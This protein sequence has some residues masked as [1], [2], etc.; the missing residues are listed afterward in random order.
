VL[1]RPSPNKPRV[2]FASNPAEAQAQRGPS[3]A[4]A[5]AP[6]P[7]QPVAR[8]HV[9]QHM[10]S[11]ELERML[12]NTWEKLEFQPEAGGDVVSARLPS[13]QR[14]II[15]IDHRQRTVTL[16]GPESVVGQWRKVVAVL[17]VKPATPDETSE[18][19]P[20]GK[21]DPAQIQYAIKLL[22]TAQQG[23]AAKQ[24]IQFVGQEQPE[25]APR[26]P[27]GEP[28]A[29]MV[30]EADAEGPIGPVT[31]EILEDRII[32]R[33]KARDVA[34]VRKIIQ[35]IIRDFEVIRP[36][37]EVHV[38]K[39]LNDR[40]VADLI[41]QIYDTVF[42]PRTARV[43]ITPLVKPNALLLIGPRTAIE[44]VK[45]LI[46]KLDQP[47]SPQTQ[48]KVF[49]LQHISAVDAETTVRTF[50]TDRPPLVSQEAVRTGLGTRVNVV[51]E[52][53][54]NSLI[55]QASPR[56]LVEVGDL[57]KRLDV[58][59]S[60]AT[61]EVRVFRLRNSLA[62]ELAPVLQDAI[63][64][65]GAPRAT[66]GQQQPG[67]QPTGQP[68]ATGTRSETTPRSAS[69]QF[70]QIDERGR[71]IIESGILS[72]VRVNA[73][74]RA[75][76]LI[77][78]GP[79]ASMEL[80]AALIDQLD[81]LPDAAASIKVF[82]LTNGDA[83][84]IITTLQ[85]LFGQ[86]T[87]Q[88]GGGGAQGLLQT[89]TT[90]GENTLVPLRFSFDQRTNSIIVSGAAGDIAVVERIL[91]RLDESDVRRRKTTVY[92]LRN[93]PALDVS[94]AIN[95][96][97]QTQRQLAQVAPGLTSQIE[98]I[99]R[100]VVVVPEQVSN[101]LLVSATP[102][103]YEEIKKIVED[104]DR[105]PPMVIIQ[106]LIAEVNLDNVDEFG[107]EFGLQDSLLFDRGIPGVG[108]PFNN[109]PLGNSN[110][111]TRENLAGQGLSHFSVGRTNSDL[112]YGGLVL[113]ASNESVSIL[114]RALQQARRLQ[115]I[116][117]P[118]VQTLDNQ[119]A[120][121][122]VGARVPFITQSTQTT[123]GI[124]NT[125]TLENIGILLGVTPRTSPD[126]LIVMEI[127][128]EK[129][130]LSPENQGIPIFV[131]NEGQI[132]RS[133]QIFITTAQTTVSATSGQT[134][135]LGGLI[136]KT[137]EQ[138]T[139]RV[140]YMSDIP[141]LG[142]LF[143]Y[144]RELNRKRELLIIMTPYVART[145]ED[146][147]MINAKETERMNWCLADVAEAHGELPWAKGVG[148]W[149]KLRTPLIFP[150]QDPTGESAAPPAGAEENRFEPTER[151]PT[152]GGVFEQQPR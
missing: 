5:A 20:L 124:Q 35:D 108:F 24:G 57:L 113:S 88:G 32:V 29:P 19:L 130:E 142:R 36:E 95:Q 100:E 7:A 84:T 99:E 148:P 48:L 89:V 132:I 1:D 40:A 82:T 114:I 131:S 27:P 16:E 93:A 51:A 104:L 129:S 139:R 120:F 115:V 128:A 38:L 144:D 69:L 37:I 31:I 41:G 116:S 107:A 46:T 25:P 77:V 118:Q 147:E 109:L 26:Q 81:Q 137:R 122:Q 2:I 34:R 101:S 121:V 145:D 133:P 4:P 11:R 74:P 14:A 50:F 78:R 65:Q 18:I 79:S 125:T 97:L 55:V 83:Q 43:S 54:S 143:R 119:P 52:F 126:G 140:P 111:A 135:I 96:F 10:S 112:G 134:V 98:Q 68:S 12:V 28:D 72:D 87:G 59:D 21:A 33:G 136:T 103:Y 39:H 22:R 61:S 47:V 15:R 70:L 13:M 56:D 76:A 44:A 127:N 49:P 58:P 90:G 151:E 62:E 60:P 117:R 17:D 150:D 71:R 66:G 92:R 138:E 110:T 105:R 9:L 94:N 123:F 152:P 45:E 23:A 73:D 67:Q 63:T 149:N 6:P 42:G 141:V 85:Q 64:G 53:R 146:I 80:M 75:N 8:P 30:D 86:Q 106:V 102:R 91:Y 3:P